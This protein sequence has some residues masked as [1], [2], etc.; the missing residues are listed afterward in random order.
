MS[1]HQTELATAIPAMLLLLVAVSLAISSARS[2]VYERGNQI[3]K[4]DP[5]DEAKHE[6]TKVPAPRRR[7]CC[8]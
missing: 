2:A 8:G 5:W 4:V 3:A 6:P 7:K 1:C